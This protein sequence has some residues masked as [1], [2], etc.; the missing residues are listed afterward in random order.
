MTEFSEPFVWGLKICSFD[1][2]R[3]VRVEEKVGDQEAMEV[4]E[5]V[6]M[7]VVEPMVVVSMS[8]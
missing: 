5:I 8:E 6:E 1:A 4:V 7:I 3:T 2:C